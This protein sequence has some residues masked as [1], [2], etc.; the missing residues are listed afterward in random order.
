[1]ILREYLGLVNDWKG[2]SARPRS[3]FKTSC[4]DGMLQNCQSVAVTSK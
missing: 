2:S 4:A 3:Y 1:M